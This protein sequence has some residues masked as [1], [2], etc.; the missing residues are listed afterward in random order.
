LLPRMTGL[1]RN[2]DLKMPAQLIR[3]KTD[4]RARIES[5]QVNDLDPDF[6]ATTLIHTGDP[7]TV[8]GYL[9]IVTI[10]ALIMNR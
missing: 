5:G 6:D 10:D 7:L 8:D 4:L 2:Q 1:E 9:G 3:S